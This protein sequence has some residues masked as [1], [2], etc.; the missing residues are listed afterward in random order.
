MHQWGVKWTYGSNFPIPVDTVENIFWSIGF[1]LLRHKLCRIWIFFFNSA[2]CKILLISR[3]ASF[4]TIEYNLSMASE[5]SFCVTSECDLPRLADTYTPFSVALP[6]SLSC[7][8]EYAALQFY[9]TLTFHI[10]NEIIPKKYILHS[11]SVIR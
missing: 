1:F 2:M 11:K 3:Q 5:F 10:F 7:L 4:L 8:D 6:R 9:Y